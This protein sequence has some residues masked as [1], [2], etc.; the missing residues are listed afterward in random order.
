ML[1]RSVQVRLD[2]QVEDPSAREKF[3]HKDLRSWVKQNRGELIGAV[4]TL[5]Q[6]WFASHCPLFK[7]RTLG[8]FERWVQ[9]VGGILGA[10]DIP[11]F[12]E[13]RDRFRHDADEEGAAWQS[14]II[15]W[16]AKSDGA[17]TG[18]EE[19]FKIAEA[20]LGPLLGDGNE[21][22]Q[23]TRF[24]ILLKQHRDWV[25][26]EW[27]LILEDI[28]DRKNRSRWSLARVPRAIEL[29]APDPTP[30]E[31]MMLQPDYR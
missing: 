31:P 29:R 20:E 3:K 7:D 15:R 10:A 27:K 25:F 9:V 30:A 24:G 21:H 26:G 14:F 11:G 12:L 16:A 19:L 28:K 8:S 6:H 22:S 18:V 17:P 5:V 1:R 4:L 13:N 2:A 23:R